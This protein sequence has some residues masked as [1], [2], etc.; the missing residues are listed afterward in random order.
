MKTSTKGTASQASNERL[1]DLRRRLRAK[2]TRACDQLRVRLVSSDELPW[3]AVRAAYADLTAAVWSTGGVPGLSTPPKSVYDLGIRR[4]LFLAQGDHL[5]AMTSLVQTSGPDGVL[6]KLR[7]TVSASYS[8]A[9]P[10]TVRA[11]CR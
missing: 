6:Q 4:T 8:H 5:V 2:I 7:N 3:E 10:S 9:S 11:R 1:E